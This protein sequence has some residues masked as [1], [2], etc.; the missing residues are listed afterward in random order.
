MFIVV[1]LCNIGTIPNG[2]RLHVDVNRS[3]WREENQSKQI[4][5]DR[6][7]TILFNHVNTL[8]F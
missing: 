2:Y 8:C 1:A 6:E 7:T 3:V 4:F 5:L